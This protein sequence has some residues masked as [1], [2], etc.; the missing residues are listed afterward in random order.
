[1][2]IMPK[3]LKAGV[4]VVR[5]EADGD[6]FLTSLENYHRLE[7]ELLQEHTRDGVLINSCNKGKDD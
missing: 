3:M 6:K 7:C 1:M 2:Q 5:L 4:L